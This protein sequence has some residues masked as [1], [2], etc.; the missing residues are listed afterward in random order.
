MVQSAFV[1][2]TVAEIIGWPV[3]VSCATTCVGMLCLF[4]LLHGYLYSSLFQVFLYCSICC[5]FHSC[6]PVILPVLYTRTH[7]PQMLYDHRT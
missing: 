4:R 7:L 6:V 5:I 1:F 3:S 2:V